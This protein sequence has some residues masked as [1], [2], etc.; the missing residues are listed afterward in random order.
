MTSEPQFFFSYTEFPTPVPVSGIGNSTL[1][2]R[3]SGTTF[4]QSLPDLNNTSIHRFD[5]V[6]LVPG[7]NDSIISKHWTKQHGLSTSLDDQENIVLASND[8]RSTFK[9]TTQ[10]IGKITV[11][12]HVQ[13][14]IYQPSKVF[15]ISDAPQR[16]ISTASL[17]HAQSHAHTRTIT[18]APQRHS[19]IPVYIKHNRVQPQ[20]RYQLSHA[21]LMHE[22]LAHTSA[23]R[24]RL[25]GI[26]YFPGN[27]SDYVLGK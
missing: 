19:R 27:C 1:Y 20:R 3:G 10:S 24:L 23:D 21:Q 18:T 13:A 7:L 5:N 22:R 9:A 8:P 4:L 6:W 12:P 16:L 17:R 25:I 11:F 26:K 15:S 14:L 2:A